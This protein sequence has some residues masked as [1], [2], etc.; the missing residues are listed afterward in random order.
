MYNF[1]LTL[2][3]FYI[4]YKTPRTSM[5]DGP[6]KNLKLNR[7]WKRFAEAVQNAAFDH[8]ECCAMASDALVREILTDGVLALLADLQAYASRKQLDL[9]LL[10]S[11]ES[12]FNIHMKT[13]FT[14]TMQKEIAFCLSEQAVPADAVR[15]ALKASVNEQI[16]EAM[17]RIE[18][19]CIRAREVGE[20]WQD[21]FNHTVKQA[22]ATFN[23][24]AIDK[25][26]EALLAGNKNAF[27]KAVSKKVGLDEGAC[28]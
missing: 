18:E 15:Q 6:F 5:S 20:M 22:S 4:I 3:G 21:Q 8:A 19:E 26:C 25:I 1:I 24:L 16:S 12:I 23:T 2:S 13:P 7:R 17:N 28:L 27:K 10:S 14:D 11:V 9:D